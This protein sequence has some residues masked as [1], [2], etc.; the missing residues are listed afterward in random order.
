MIASSINAFCFFGLKTR[1]SK[2]DF[3]S[4]AVF[5]FVEN[6]KF[7]ETFSRSLEFFASFFETSFEGAIVPNIFGWVFFIS[8]TQ[9]PFR[10]LLFR[11]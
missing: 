3:E 11:C 10:T 1:N 9:L 2:M 7:I 4:N 5:F 8:R 6:F